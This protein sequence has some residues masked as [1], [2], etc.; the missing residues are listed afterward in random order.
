MSAVSATLMMAAG[1]GLTFAAPTYVI[2]D[3]DAGCTVSVR[4]QISSTPCRLGEGFG[5]FQG[6][7][8]VQSRHV[9]P[10]SAILIDSKQGGARG[11]G[12]GR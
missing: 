12:G 9:K 3:V 7:S 4:R 6:G 2:R 11:G 8:T 1:F 5:C 10:P